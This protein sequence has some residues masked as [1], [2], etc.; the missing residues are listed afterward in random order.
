MRPIQWQM[1][2]SRPRPLAP[3]PTLRHENGQMLPQFL[4]LSW[5][6]AVVWQQMQ[7]NRVPQHRLRFRAILIAGLLL[8]LPIVSN[9]DEHALKFG[10]SFTL[11][12]LL[13]EL[14]TFS[15]TEVRI[16][17][18][19][20]GLSAARPSMAEYVV[21]LENDQFKGTARFSVNY[22]TTAT[23]VVSAR[24]NNVMEFTRVALQVRVEEK[25]YK[26]NILV[27]DTY[28]SLEIKLQSDTRTLR[29]WTTSQ[30]VTPWGIEFK[31]RSFVA[32]TSE[33]GSALGPVWADLGVIEGLRRSGS[34]PQQR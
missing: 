8:T 19:W 5:G 14:A 11:T 30:T 7:T 12:E 26:P 18:G 23:G 2:Q 28:P 9:A 10:P 27:T 25:P 13:P 24:R 33:L 32:D 20:D 4:G 16:V 22:D 3:P 31:N 15:P 17:H 6:T 34:Q 1:T 21:K 29:I